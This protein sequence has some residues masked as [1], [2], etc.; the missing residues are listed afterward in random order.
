MNLP[1]IPSVVFR[2]TLCCCKAALGILAVSALM[3]S[4]TSP[5]ASA[6]T[7][8]S[9]KL[10]KRPMMAPLRRLAFLPTD[11]NLEDARR[12][13]SGQTALRGLLAQ[14]LAGDDF[15]QRFNTQLKAVAD[16]SGR[17]WTLDAIGLEVVAG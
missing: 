16:A 12:Y 10:G 17:F 7:Q 8:A 15:A 1:L 9:T 14:P 4:Y 2:G 3:S 5:E 13:L 11:H 6:M